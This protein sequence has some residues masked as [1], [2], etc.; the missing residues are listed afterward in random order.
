ML[1]YN[2]PNCKGDDRMDSDGKTHKLHCSIIT[3]VKEG[4]LGVARLRTIY[5]RIFVKEYSQE[6]F[7]EIVEIIHN[8]NSVLAEEFVD[9]WMMWYRDECYF[10]Y[11]RWY[12]MKAWITKNISRDVK[13]NMSIQVYAV[14]Y[15]ITEDEMRSKLNK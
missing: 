1:Q 5:K 4:G 15:G 9:V 8:Y 7:N 10:P 12:S 13:D 3:K 2:S 14:L 11:Y 6:I